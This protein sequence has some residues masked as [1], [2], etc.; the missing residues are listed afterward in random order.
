MHNPEYYFQ[1]STY[2]FFEKNK[3]FSDLAAQISDNSFFITGG[4]GVFGTWILHYFKWLIT[5]KIAS[6]R[7]TLLT[8][9]NKIAYK[10]DFVE[11]LK[12][13]IVNFKYPRKNFDYLLHLAAPSAQD[14]FNGMGDI[15]KID[16]LYLGTKNIINFANNSIKSR[17]LMTS[18]GAIYGGFSQQ[19][20]E[21][22]SEDCRISPLSTENSSGLAIGKK[23][24]E[25]LFM[26]SKS[27][28]EIDVSIARCFSFAGPGLPFNLHY[29]L[30][31][32][33]NNVIEGRNIKING[34][35]KPV[36]S[37][38]YL[39]DM[40]YWLLNIL[41]KGK[42][43]RDYN[44]GSDLGINMFHL[45]S[46]IIEIL[47]PSKSVELLGL[48]NKTK[49]NPVNF[50]YVPSVSRAKTELNLKLMTSLNDSIILYASYIK[51]IKGL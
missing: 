37:F 20:N 14:T 9:N 5:K 7:V 17:S 10:Y 33:I 43:G 8:R 22:I 35:G 25:T 1:N 26:L 32:F 6:P 40:V 19:Q 4:S 31:N 45:A 47:D 41:F 36:R 27:S 12:G 30:G 24:S 2:D 34:D 50:F 23:V 44:V 48:S 42:N 49:G 46:L 51:K 28:G 18:S 3:E 16:Q 13:N 38:M 11:I 29:A 39:G 21:L 15:E